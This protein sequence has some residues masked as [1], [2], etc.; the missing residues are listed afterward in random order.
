[1]ESTGSFSQE[2]LGENLAKEDE[3]QE[4]EP[5]PN[6][7]SR[8]P[9]SCMFILENGDEC[10]KSFPNKGQLKEHRRSTRHLTEDRLRRGDCAG[11]APGFKYPKCNWRGCGI[12]WESVHTVTTHQRTEHQGFARKNFTC[13]FVNGE[14]VRCGVQFESKTNFDTHWSP[15][16]AVRAVDPSGGLAEMAQANTSFPATASS[17]PGPAHSQPTQST[18]QV[19]YEQLQPNLSSSSRGLA[20]GQLTHYR[21][22]PV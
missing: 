20:P 18:Q 14:G 4:D 9:N 2:H 16:H 5:A 17:Q 7:P 3:P 8:P 19:P 6:S 1:M 15:K 10:R 13:N 11:Q 12:V 21:T 22:D